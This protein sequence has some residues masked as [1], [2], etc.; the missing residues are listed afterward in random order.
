MNES[1]HFKQATDPMLA[2]PCCGKGG[3]SVA[4]LMIL[5]YIK[6]YFNGA[7]VH[8]TSCGR[9]I[10]YNR[11]IG[12][13]DGSQHVVKEENNWTAEAVDIVVDGHTPEDVR[14]ALYRLP[15]AH[16]LG[17]GY[18]RDEFTHIDARGYAARWDG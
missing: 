7:T 17:I 10:P 14:M 9:C 2:C 3:P 4:V 13:T 18:Y 1:R 11:S 5:E 16:L 15:Y 6:D 12:S 8:V